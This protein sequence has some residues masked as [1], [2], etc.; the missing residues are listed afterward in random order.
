MLGI[1]CWKF[2]VTLSPTSCADAGA[3]VAITIAADA[4]PITVRIFMARVLSL[5]TQ[6]NASSWVGEKHQE[7]MKIVYYEAVTKPFQLKLD[8]SAKTPLAEQIRRGIGVAIESGVLVP[9]ARLP[10]WQDLAAPPR[11]ARGPRRAAYRKPVAA[12]RHLATAPA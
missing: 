9:R 10:S 7:C 1:A 4:A 6:I 2:G 8:R 12:Q 5:D 11:V 3:A